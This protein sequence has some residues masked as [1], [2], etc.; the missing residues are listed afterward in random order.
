M[1][2]QGAVP[3]RPQTKDVCTMYLPFL[4]VYGEEQQRD[5]SAEVTAAIRLRINYVLFDS[6]PSIPVATGR[7]QNA[8]PFFGNDLVRTG[9]AGEF[10]ADLSHYAGDNTTWMNAA[11]VAAKAGWRAEVHSITPTDFQSEIAGFEA[12]NA[13]VPITDLRWVVAHVPFITPDQATHRYSG[14]PSGIRTRRGLRERIAR[15]EARSPA[16]DGARGRTW[17]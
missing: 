16:A 14:A 8:F 11:L 5:V 12:V 7:I 10:L 3:G 2:P 4:A 15:Q 6:D 1:P 17:A 13:Q 9:G